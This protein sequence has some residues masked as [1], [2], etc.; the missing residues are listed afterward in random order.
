MQSKRYHNSLLSLVYEKFVNGLRTQGPV[1]YIIML[2]YLD[3]ILTEAKKK[4]QQK[5]E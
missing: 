5:K 1:D 4:N 3:I 2:D